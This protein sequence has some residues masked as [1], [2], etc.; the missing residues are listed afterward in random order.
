MRLHTAFLKGICIIAFLLTG[1]VQDRAQPM[2]EKGVLDLTSWD[3]DRNGSVELNGEWA[4]YWRQ[5][6]SPD[7]FSSDN[8]PDKASFTALPGTWTKQ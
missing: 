6:L 1:C 2:A 4:F 7:D 8:I 3:F 5:L